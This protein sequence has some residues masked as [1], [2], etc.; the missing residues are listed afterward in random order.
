MQSYRFL[1]WELGSGRDVIAL[2]SM[3]VCRHRLYNFFV[4][5]RFKCVY[6]CEFWQAEYWP[7]PFSFCSISQYT[8]AHNCRHPYYPSF[9]RHNLVNVQCIYTKISR[10]QPEIR[11]CWSSI[12][13]V[14]RCLYT[15][16]SCTF[17]RCTRRWQLQKTGVASVQLR[18]TTLW[19][20]HTRWYKY[21]YCDQKS[22]YLS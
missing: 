9:Q 17:D 21:T 2:P 19:M 4:N 11:L 15:A 10:S 1:H 7:S 20:M 22:I 6:F 12:I 8:V 14:R 5:L 16:A 3:E 13:I 18:A